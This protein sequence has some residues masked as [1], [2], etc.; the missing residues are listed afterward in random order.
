MPYAAATSVTSS[1]SREELSKIL[2]R[3]GAS[4]FGYIQ[5][6]DFVSVGF[7]KDQRTIRFSIPMPDK[8]SRE[9]THS[10]ERGVVRS[11][12]TAERAYEQAV[13]QKWRALVLVV[14]AKLEAV[15]AGIAEFEQE[16]FSYTVVGGMTVYERMHEQVTEAIST[17]R[18]VTLQLGLER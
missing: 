14:K 10:P 2:S 13:H 9:F 18:P 11:T 3:Y 4:Q 16:F 17:G 1:Q 5:G 8:N 7:V 15:D 6:K 12:S